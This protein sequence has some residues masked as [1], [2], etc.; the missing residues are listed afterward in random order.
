M[1]EHP[2][3][4]EFDPTPPG[5]PKVP[6][7]GDRIAFLCDD[8]VATYKVVGEPAEGEDGEWSFRMEPS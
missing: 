4:I 7:E 6:K 3:S 1:S 2:W 5:P 8:G